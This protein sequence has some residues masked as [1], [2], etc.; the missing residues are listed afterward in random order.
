MDVEKMIRK[1]YVYGEKQ[2]DNT[3]HIAF[4]LDKSYVRPLGVMMTSILTYNK[5]VCFHVFIDEIEDN[6]LRRLESTVEKYHA[7]CYCYIV[8]PEIFKDFPQTFGWHTAMYFRFLAFEH[9]YLKGIRR[10]LYLDADMLCMGNLRELYFMSLEGK[11]IAAV[12]D[13]GLPEGRLKRID[14]TGDG[15]FNSGMLMVDLCAWHDNKNFDTAISMLQKTP[16][17]FEAPDQDVL[18]LLYADKVYWAGKRYNQENNVEDI[19]PENTVIVHY[20]ST[21]KPWLAWY[22]CSGKNFWQQCSDMSEW[23]DV[24]IIQNPRTVREKRLLSRTCFK[25]GNFWQGI[26][27]YCRYLSSK[28]S[29]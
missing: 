12:K 6:D 8:N 1:E 24:P 17:R 19:Y 11:E 5:S 4:G 9:C 14:F 13:P 28:I 10:L 21:P 2:G 25:K 7:C 22:Y 3:I 18:N 20:T 27:W 23:S 29:A 16:E 26:I 15:Y